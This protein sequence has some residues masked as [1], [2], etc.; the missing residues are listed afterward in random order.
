MT[1]RFAINTLW[2]LLGQIS[3]IAVGI[4]VLPALI[5]CMGL[6]RYGFITLVWV[7]VGY[8]GLF[9][10]GIGRALTRVVAYR[11]G[12]DDKPGALHVANVGM[13]YL[14]MFGVLIGLVFATAGA[15]FVDHAMHL[16]AVLRPEAVNAMYLLAVS[17]PFVML[18]TGYAG[19]LSAY[20]EFKGINL[21]KIALGIG[22]YVGPLMVARWVNRLDYVVAFVLAMR[23]VTNFAHAL[24]C[25]Q[26]CSFR[27]RP[28]APDRVT[29]KE[30]FDLGGWMS[31]SN[32]VSP[33]L[34]YLD[35]LLLGALVPIK[36][37]AYYATPYDVISK[38]LILPYSILAAVFPAATS[39]VVGSQAA[40]TMMFSSLRV[41]FLIMFPVVF[42]FFV[43]AHAGLS[44]WLGPSFAEQ[45]APIMQILAVGILFNA[46]A[47]APA[48]MIQAAG[49]PRWMA[50]LHVLELPV[51][52]GALWW[53]TSR[54]G[55]MGAALASTLRNCL[56]ALAVFVLALRGTVRTEI[57]YKPALGP[58]IL[59]ALLFAG[60]LLPQS[61][62]AAL[63]YLAG[64]L[65]IF[66]VYAWAY[67]LQ[68]DE[69]LHLLKVLR[70]Q[71]MEQSA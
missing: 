47:Q 41:L 27:F 13:T 1:R 51:F 17:I 20:Q 45:G 31:V 24:V 14:L 71:P 64:G 8:A 52:I 66:V 60:G 50:Q 43:L 32:L 59:T 37:V 42:V 18:T 36:M 30:L 68:P 21:I 34:S 70:A 26:V 5:R 55:I 35:R 3:P 25:R 28:Y 9:D 7:L 56:D 33:F 48:M 44:V 63:G 69:R 39:V 22:S 15:W 6:D 19:I 61:G 46:L 38:S 16:P 65:V 12:Q 67:L 40:R 62:W 4:L 11:L 53:L 23:V 57:N 2:N 58:S 54:Y 29:S 10:F 49:H